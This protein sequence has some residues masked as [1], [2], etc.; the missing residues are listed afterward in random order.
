MDLRWYDILQEDGR[1]STDYL[2]P[3]RRKRAAAMRDEADRL[4]SVAGEV[5][6]RE[7]LA[8][9]L[10]CAPAEAPLVY[11]EDGKPTAPGTG[12]YVSVS[13][14]GA[15]V[16]CVVDNAPI[17]VDVETFRDVEDKFMRRVCSETEL[18]YVLRGG[19]RERR[20]WELWT[21]KE[22]IFKLTGHGP[23]LRLSKLA[24]PDG[25]TVCYTERFGCAM[26]VARGELWNE[27]EDEQ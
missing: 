11:D 24:L 1:P 17:G 27:W 8:Q 10:G 16:V 6:A 15:Y 18:A 22:A 9:R 3:E 14:S 2:N 4:R 7:M 26:T 21:A 20:F 19:D 13:H 12:L 25:V 23:L 5:M